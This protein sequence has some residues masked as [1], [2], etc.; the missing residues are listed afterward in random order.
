MIG[1]DVQG[2]TRVI[3]LRRNGPLRRAHRRFEAL[4]QRRQVYLW[5]KHLV[6]LLCR[7]DR[8]KLIL[9]RRVLEHLT[10][11]EPQGFRVR[12]D[13][14]A[15]PVLRV[16]VEVGLGDPLIY[17]SSDFRLQMDHICPLLDFVAQVLGFA[18]ESRVLPAQQQS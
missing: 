1:Q 17:H 9:Q 16:K 3:C 14:F 6:Y 13:L 10:P 2:A 5:S 12:H 15:A 7:D 11:V 18:H 8:L 4:P